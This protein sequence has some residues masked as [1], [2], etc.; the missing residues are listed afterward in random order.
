MYHGPRGLRS[1]LD[2]RMCGHDGKHPEFQNPSHPKF[3]YQTFRR[4]GDFRS[5]VSVTT[6]LGISHA[7]PKVVL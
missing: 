7:F 1:E 4:A 5:G 3:D 2:D 6:M